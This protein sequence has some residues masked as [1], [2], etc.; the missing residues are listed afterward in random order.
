[1]LWLGRLGYAALGVIFG[2]IGF[3]LIIAAFQQNPSQA[4]GLA[5]ALHATL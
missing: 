1:V 3:F 2:E 4:Q 5:G